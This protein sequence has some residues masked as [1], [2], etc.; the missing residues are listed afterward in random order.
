MQQIGGKVSQIAKKTFTSILFVSPTPNGE[1]ASLMKKRERI[2]NE[3]SNMNIKIVEKSGVPFFWD[4][5]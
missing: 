1:L 2:L 3:N 5:K 4:P